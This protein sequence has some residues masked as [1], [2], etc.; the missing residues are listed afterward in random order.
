MQLPEG[1]LA[2]VVVVLV[3]VVGTGGNE[4]TVGLRPLVLGV[5]AELPVGLAL[6]V[7]EPVHPLRPD[8]HACLSLCQSWLRCVSQAVV[9]RSELQQTPC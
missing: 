2:G 7:L 1:Q 9:C 5:H 8:E 4:R 3:V 6:L